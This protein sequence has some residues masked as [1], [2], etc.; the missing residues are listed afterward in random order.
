MRFLLVL[1]WFCL[2]EMHGHG[3]EKQPNNFSVSAGVGWFYYVN[4]LKT[5]ANRVVKDQ[6]GFS[7][8]LLWE[9]EHRLSL[10]GEVGY[11]TIYTVKIDSAGTNSPIGEARLSAIP[12]LLCFKIRITPHLY[13]AGGQG[14]SVLVSHI[15]AYGSTIESTKLS[16]ADVN[17]SVL[18][19]RPIN[20]RFRIEGE[21]KYLHFGKTEDFGFS[22]Q[23]V[24]YYL[25]RFKSKKR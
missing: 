13:V 24:V 4:T 7:S 2:V 22:L 21:L 11:Y 15:T 12:I 5:Q 1:S 10:G 6:I 17:L 19:R 23:A 18:Y 3:Q 14:L 8:R 20:D 9:P 25:F 16:L